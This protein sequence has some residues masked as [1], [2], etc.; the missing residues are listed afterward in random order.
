MKHLILL[1][2]ML[3]SLPALCYSQRTPEELLD[4]KQILQDADCHWFIGDT[5]FNK[6]GD[7]VF[8]CTITRYDALIYGP[9]PKKRS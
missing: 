3:L 7:T 1:A 8:F 2:V 6:N 5:A 9:C 4:Y